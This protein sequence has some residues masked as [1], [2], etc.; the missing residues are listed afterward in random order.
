MI[1]YLIYENTMQIGHFDFSKCVV[2][3]WLVLLH[4]SVY[5]VL[6][7][8]I[9]GRGWTVHLAADTMSRHIPSEGGH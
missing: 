4:L 7:C 1:W 5:S 2:T 9:R 8:R 6:P 3:V